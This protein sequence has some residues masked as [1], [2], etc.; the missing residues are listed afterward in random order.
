[1]S[2]EADIIA[3]ITGALGSLEVE[4]ALDHFAGEIRD[5]AK[6]LAP[7]FDP[8]R[9]RRA[10]PGIG[11][12][13]GDFRNSIHVRPTRSVGERLVGSDSPIAMWQELGTEHFPEDAIFAKT[14][15]HFGGTGPVFS[16]GVQ[17]AQHQLRGELETLAEMVA[18]R[19]ASREIAAQ[20]RAIDLARM[21]R[22][23]AFRAERQRRYR[24]NRRGR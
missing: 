15:V 24:S 2:S 5:Y 10:T 1:M 13:A 11:E 3:D 18:A 16:E 14:A 20:K 22:S 4:E 7:V 23:A 17:H 9:D 8:E 21:Q 19:A 6:S 12:E